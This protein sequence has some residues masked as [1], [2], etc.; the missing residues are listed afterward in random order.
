MFLPKVI[1]KKVSRALEAD[2]LYGFLFHNKWGWEKRILRAHP[3]LKNV[4]NYQKAAD[5][6]RYL[7]EYTRQYP[8]ENE[9]RMRKNIKTHQ[10]RW[11]QLEI[12]YFSTLAEIMNIVWPKNHSII[13]ALVSINPIC[14]RFLEDWSFLFSYQET[15]KEGLEIIMHESCHFL[16][17]NKWKEAFPKSNPKTFEYPHLEW[18][19]S[20]ILAP[21]ILG[22]SRIQKLLCKRPDFYKEHKRLKIDGTP[23][24]ERFKKLY[25]QHLKNQSSFSNFLK[26]AYREVKKIEK[27]LSAL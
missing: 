18:H 11:Q 5:R 13:T 24:P 26:D 8:I 19:L 4:Y 27:K 23:V 12:A 9:L 7:R 17:F 21:V 25:G 2:L 6:K 1:F 15:A 10:K 3:Q 22:D 20:E 14:P 16:Y